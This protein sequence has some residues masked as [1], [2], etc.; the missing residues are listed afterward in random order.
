MLI[1]AGCDVNK[2]NAS[3]MT[4]LHSIFMQ[5]NIQAAD[6]LLSNNANFM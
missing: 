3:G 1:N 5:G 6:L 2:Q 4:A